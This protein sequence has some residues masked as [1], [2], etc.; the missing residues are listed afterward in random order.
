MADVKEHQ[1][2][3]RTTFEFKSEMP[4]AAIFYVSHKPDVVVH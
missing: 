2:F 1:S 3:I 4:V